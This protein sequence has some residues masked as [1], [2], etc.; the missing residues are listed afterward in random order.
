M[1][2]ELDIE[3]LYENAPCGYLS[4]LPDM[5]IV[6]LN[7]TLANWLG[8][9]VDALIG[10]DFTQ[11]LTAGGRIHYET[12]FGPILRMSGQL[13]GI[14]IDFVTS[15]RRRLPVFMTANVKT[16]E[17][18]TPVLIRITALDARDRRTY[19]RELLESRTRAELLAKTL[20]RSLLPPALLP[21]SGMT[22]AAH[23]HAASSDEVGGDFY[24]LFPLSDDRWGFFLGD[25]CGKGAS[26]AAVTSLTRYT[27]RAAAVYDHDPVAVLHNLDSV[28]RQEF[29]ENNA[30]FCT[31]VFGVL[32]RSAGGF[33]VSMASGGHPPP[34]VM[35][36]DGSA[37]YVHMTGGQLVGILR[38]ARFVPATVTLSAGDTLMLY[39]D[40]LT[41]ARVGTGRYD[42][43]G[44]L[45]EFASAHAP[46]TPAMIVEDLRVLL[47][48]F[49]TGLADDAAVMA[50]GV[51]SVESGEG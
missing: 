4:V 30:Q 5:R 27:L 40:G 20:Q 38:H 35:R 46:A 3:D 51:S 11:L 7:S 19:E 34:L 16:D 31:A 33:E 18:D 49:G 22:A 15:D 28:L 12:H 10:T 48:S 39:T 37:Q 45:L 32:S 2:N 17:T 29:R 25:V 42:D 50:L 26:A 47:N 6:R 8:F 23:Y 24:D 43:E 41:E 44:A 13:D 36:A 21:P 9:D 14:A 1:I